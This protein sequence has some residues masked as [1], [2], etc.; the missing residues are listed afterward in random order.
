MRA[1]QGLSS[2]GP[3]FPVCAGGKRIHAYAK[4]PRCRSSRQTAPRRQ[5]S[6]ALDIQRCL[7]IIYHEIEIEINRIFREALLFAISS[8]RPV[9]IYPVFRRCAANKKRRRRCFC[10]ALWPSHFSRRMLSVRGQLSICLPKKPATACASLYSVSPGAALPSPETK[11]TQP[12][13]SPSAM[14]GAATPT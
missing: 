7:L 2:G 5:A 12:T 4:K 9:R 14:M 1:R 3:K 11:S 13:T 10:P 8:A 6:A